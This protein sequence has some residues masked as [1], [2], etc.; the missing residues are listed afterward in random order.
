MHYSSRSTQHTF[1][2]RGLWFP[3]DAWRFSL[4]FKL[5]LL[6][7]PQAE[8]KSTKEIT[9]KKNRAVPPSRSSRKKNKK[10]KKKNEMGSEGE[11]LRNPRILCLHGFRTSGEILKKQVEKWPQSILQN[12]DLVYPNAPFPAQG[13]SDVEGIF[14]PPYYEWFQ[15]NKVGRFQNLNFLFLSLGWRVR[16]QRMKFLLLICRNLQSTPILTS[17]FNT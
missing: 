2:E 3:H 16:S 17:V 1:D 7:S 12:L 10:K 4:I 15:F 5:N 8:I 11:I 9:K 14:D 6:A 13:K